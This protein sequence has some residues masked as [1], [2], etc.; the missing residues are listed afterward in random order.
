MPELRVDLVSFSLLEGGLR[1]L[2]EGGTAEPWRLPGRPLDA[3]LSLEEVALRTLVAAVG[4]EPGALEQLFTYGNPDR[5]PGRRT[6][7]CVYLALI[8][9]GTTD[10]VRGFQGEWHDP[11]RL[12]AMIHDHGSIVAY[13]LT[14]LRYKLEYTAIGFE[15]LPEQFTLPEL[16]RAYEAVLGE[17]LDK[18][19]FRRRILA[20]DVIEPARGFRSSDGR[21]A[22][23]Y[24]Y[25]DDA[26]AEG[27]ARRLFP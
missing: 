22:R 3:R 25:R 26:V 10:L 1:V 2:L 20:A 4:R 21:P 14:R 17:P 16:Q 24:R 9:A 12:P 27:K 13:A 7:S 18:R 6:V 19:N 11:I 5:V 23:L 15:L 8:R